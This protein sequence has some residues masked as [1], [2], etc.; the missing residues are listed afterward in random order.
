MKD[1]PSAM[2]AVLAASVGKLV[3]CIKI[4]Q[5]DR[6]GGA[7]LT[8]TEHDAPL[9]DDTDGLTYVPLAGGAVSDVA[10]DVSLQA[11]NLSVTTA[12]DDPNPTFASIVAGDWDNAYVEVFYLYWPE[13]SRGRHVLKGGNIGEVSTALSS[14]TTEIRG[15]IQRL[16]QSIVDVTQPSCRHRFGDGSQWMGGCNNDG[17]MSPDDWNVTGTLSGVSA[18]GVELSSSAFVELSPPPAG[19]AGSFAW[20][21]VVLTSGD[22]AGRVGEVKASESGKVRLHLP[23]PYPVTAGTSFVAYYGCD[24]LRDTC[25]NTFDNFLNFDGEPDLPNLDKTIAVARS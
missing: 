23:F 17:T 7:T 10:S 18:D 16:T 15:I 8:F 4:V 25:I 13:P 22:N 9:V 5:Q 12:M 14:S 19:G 3:R 2:R 11:G 6:F 21:R 1:T 24:G 20:G